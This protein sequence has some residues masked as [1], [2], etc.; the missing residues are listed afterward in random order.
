MYFK[1]HTQKIESFGSMKNNSPYCPSSY[2]A[3]SHL[4]CTDLL[5]DPT[6]GPGSIQSI[7]TYPS[8]P[9]LSY[10]HTWSDPQ[11][12]HILSTHTVS[13]PIYR[14]LLTQSLHTYSPT[15]IRSYLQ[16]WMHIYAGLNVYSIPILHLSTTD[17]TLVHCCPPPPP[18]PPIPS[19]HPTSA[20]PQ[21][22]YTTH[23]MVLMGLMCC[24]DVDFL[25]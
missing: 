7:P 17:P 4:H 9:I 2:Q 8:T 14:A 5:S 10:L 6:W 19:P 3:I 15:P 1:N 21:K 12:P 18:P 13:D 11:I 24:Y 23:I 16:I 20:I 25:L 22:M